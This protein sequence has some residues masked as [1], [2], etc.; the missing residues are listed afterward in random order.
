M[1]VAASRGQLGLAC[2]VLYRV[3]VEGGSVHVL[4]H[5]MP[6][7]TNRGRGRWGI[8]QSSGAFLALNT[9]SDGCN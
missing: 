5:D 3:K 8:V 6:I 4:S 2:I 9:F 1:W 7:N